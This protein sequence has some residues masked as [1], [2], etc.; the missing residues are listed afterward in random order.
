MS[1]NY[2]I[3]RKDSKISHQRFNS[4]LPSHKLNTNYNSFNGLSSA[5]SFSSKRN[6]TKTLITSVLS[7]SK[8][9]IIK[10]R[11]PLSSTN[12]LDNMHHEYPYKPDLLLKLKESLKKKNLF[13]SDDIHFLTRNFK[14]KQRNNKSSL[15]NSLSSF[16]SSTNYTGKSNLMFNSK[17][18]RKKLKLNLISQMSD[19]FQIKKN[20]IFVKN[21][22]RNN[23]NIKIGDN[24]FNITE[25][26]F[27]NF[28]DVINID[29]NNIYKYKK[30]FSE[31]F[32]I[33][34][35]K[36]EDSYFLKNLIDTY[37]YKE[38]EDENFFTSNKHSTKIKNFIIK[39]LNITLKLSSLRL[40]FYEIQSDNEDNKS[41]NNS[42]KE[43]YILNTKINFP[44]EFLSIFYGLNFEEF[45]IILL[46]LVNFDFDK[47][48]FFIDY[49]NFVNKI[50]ECKILYDFFTE[51]SFAFNFN[52]YNSKEYYSY[53]WDIKGNNK[54]IKKYLIKLLLPKITLKIN[55]A[56]KS[57]FKFYS[58]ISVKTMNNLF[59]NSF[60]NWDFFI[61]LFFSEKKLFRF[62]IN[63]IICG[64]YSN[65]KNM[66]N[67]SY[68]LTD[69]ITKINTIKKDNK[70]QSFFYTFIKE[71][72]NQNYFIN[73]I[74]PKISISLNNFHKNFDI[75][76][77]RF[78]QLNKLRKYFSP[79]HLIKYGMTIKK[80]KNKIIHNDEEKNTVPAP[81]TMRPLKRSSSQLNSGKKLSFKKY[82]KNKMKMKNE[83]VGLNP[84]IQNKENKENNEVVIKD[85]ELN[86]DKYIFNFD[87]TVLK[88]IN[89]KE[90]YKENFVSN[91]NNHDKKFNI[92]FGTLELTWVDKDGLINN[93]KFDKKI[94]RNLFKS[95]QIKW[96]LYVENNINTI[97]TGAN[98]RNAL[99]KKISLF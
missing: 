20:K 73:F 80:G 63:K 32:D 25:E 39:N 30:I 65:F 18:S 83:I 46:S 89:K 50:E 96:R 82:Y 29:K 38:N 56:N 16:K 49:N 22:G 21:N 91:N 28:V 92:N 69:S 57:K 42:T 79:E 60:N 61:F 40:I 98:K 35:F 81:K 3:I 8:R 66:K 33:N 93:Y 71:G 34:E 78:Y 10:G 64:K 68:N 67:I 74:F 76:F 90:V 59:K 14:Q 77:K 53:N 48:K 12:I 75:D 84:Q 45:I 86:L 23:I 2:N 11:R 37:Q 88:F 99:S 44:F 9:Y 55:C 5:N 52:H 87:E 62:E 41:N 54:E 1:T 24:K 13:F 94:S 7:S 97:I 51:K 19:V 58:S 72:K 47:N 15:E 43:N 85:I 95:P 4:A 70:S 36:K 31:Y 27:L 17:S 26:K 6:K